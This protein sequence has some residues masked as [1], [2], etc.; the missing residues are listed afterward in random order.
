[1]L[2]TQPVRRDE[3]HQA[4]A[5]ASTSPRQKFSPLVSLALGFRF[6]INEHHVVRLEVRDWSY[7]DSYYVNVDRLERNGA[8]GGT[9]G[10]SLTLASPTWC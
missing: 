6:F 9:V 7:L 10:G 2:C 4:P 8:Q 3:H 5:A 1:M